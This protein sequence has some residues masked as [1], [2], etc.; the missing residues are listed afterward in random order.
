[1]IEFEFELY[2]HCRCRSS[3]QEMRGGVEK[4]LTRLNPLHACA[5][6]KAGYGF[7]GF[8]SL[9]SISSVEVIGDCLF[10]CYG[11]II[12]PITDCVKNEE[13]CSVSSCKE[14]HIA[15]LLSNVNE[16]KDN[17]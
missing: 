15:K 5:C 12:W 4:Q 3:Y 1:M 8:F 10:C 11:W 14:V 9:F 13:L 7:H 2:I 6:P 17:Y 16:A